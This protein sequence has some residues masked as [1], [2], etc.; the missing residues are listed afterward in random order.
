[1]VQP[2]FKSCIV[3]IVNIHTFVDVGVGSLRVGIL[4]QVSLLRSLC[5]YPQTMFVV[6]RD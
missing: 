1:M 6:L 2:G 5:S 3:C 4:M